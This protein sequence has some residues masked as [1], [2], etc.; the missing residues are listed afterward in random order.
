MS[1]MVTPSV[2]IGPETFE[3]LAKAGKT[4]IYFHYTGGALAKLFENSKSPTFAEISKKWISEPSIFKCIQKTLKSRTACVSY[5]DNLSSETNRNFTDHHGN[6]L[7]KRTVAK[8]FHLSVCMLV[9]KSAVYKESM[10]E[11]VKQQAVMGL[12]DHYVYQEIQ[13]ALDQGKAW[14]R[15]K[16]EKKVRGRSLKDKQ[17]LVVLSLEHF[18]SCFALLGLGC[19]LAIGEFFFEL[20][21]TKSKLLKLEK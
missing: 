21:I 5:R 17:H 12:T 9:P 11:I 19:T 15:Q 16:R 18:I 10:D 20:F 1:N 8:A 3:D 7:V 4:K 6:R 2:E 14:A 13:L